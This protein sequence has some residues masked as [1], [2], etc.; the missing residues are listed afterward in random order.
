MNI[1][2]TNYFATKKDPQRGK[3]QAPHS[4]DKMKEWYNS[5]HKHDLSGVI[6][7]DHLMSV[8][9]DEYSTENLSFKKVQLGKYPLNC[10]RFFHFYDYVKNHRSE[11][12][13]VLMT[14]LFDVDF[15]GDPFILFSDEYKIYAGDEENTIGKNKWML[16]YYR[17]MENWFSD[18]NYPRN[19]FTQQTISP[20]IFGAETELFLEVSAGVIDFFERLPDR[21]PENYGG[22][23]M[24][25]FALVVRQKF[26]ERNILHGY[27]LNSRYKEYEK[28]GG[29]YIRHK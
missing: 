13:N 12:D 24:P 17:M 19:F 1:V 18:I 14:D 29:F 10:E 9:I 6:F 26:A 4:F 7:H 20:G 21:I 16:R 25:I 23:D 27:P 15:W 28:K 22:V 3:L 2:L 5:L 8:F 11:I